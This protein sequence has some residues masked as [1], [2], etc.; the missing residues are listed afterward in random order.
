MG[1]VIQVI[2]INLYLTI[3]Y[4]IYNLFNKYMIY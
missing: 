2:Y 4:K 3:Y 1:G